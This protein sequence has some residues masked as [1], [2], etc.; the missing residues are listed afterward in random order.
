MGWRVLGRT[1]DAPAPEP[2]ASVDV[3]SALVDDVP[4]EPPK[5]DES[6]Q[7]ETGP[8]ASLEDTGKAPSRTQSAICIAG[9]TQSK[10][11][12]NCGTKKRV[13]SKDGT[14]WGPFGTCGEGECKPGE[15]RTVDCEQCGKRRDVCSSQCTW[16]EGSCTEKGEC[17]PGEERDCG[18]SH[19]GCKQGKSTCDAQCRWGSCPAPSCKEFP[20]NTLKSDFN[21][22]V[23][24]IQTSVCNYD[25]QAK[26]PSGSV[27]T[28]H[29]TAPV[30]FGGRGKCSLVGAVSSGGP[31]AT[32]RLRI[33]VPASQGTGCRV[34]QC[35]CRY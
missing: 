34:D 27:S 1:N 9:Q 29:C 6:E 25:I 13:C 7:P 19:R 28:G 5:E 21:C 20:V 2:L 35:Y 12:G 11:C 31:V 33:E 17:K 22:G 24:L 16:K 23:N 4:S 26:C 30:N 15:T 32:A 14:S 18:S 8:R 10:P 3:H